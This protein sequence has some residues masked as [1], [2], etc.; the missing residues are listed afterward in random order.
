[1]AAKDRFDVNFVREYDPPAESAWDGTENKLPGPLEPYFLRANTG[2][3]WMLGG[4]MSRPFIYADQCSGK[5]A[6][7][8]IESSKVY[9]TSPFATKKLRFENVAHCFCVQEGVLKVRLGDDGSD[10]W[11]EARE[12]QT[13]LIA[14]GQAF[15]IDFGSRYV[16]AISF[17]N[18]PGIEEVVRSAGKPYAG[19]VLPEEIESW[20]E[21]AFVEACAKAGATVS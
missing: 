1:M 12:G 17:T 10:A 5:F 11:T 13:V 3:R 9:A 8:S 19:F 2:P 4:V 20:D 16:R 21:A 6:I 7:S 15:S 18:G 14:A